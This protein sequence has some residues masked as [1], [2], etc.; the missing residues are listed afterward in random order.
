[1]PYHH[2]VAVA[3]SVLWWGVYLGCFGA[4]VGALIGLFTE[5]AAATAAPAWAAAAEFFADSRRRAPF[6][7]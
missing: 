1:M 6:T 7:R 3:I 2:P 5:R 4:S